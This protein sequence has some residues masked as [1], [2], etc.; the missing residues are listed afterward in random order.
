MKNFLLLGLALITG[1]GAQA[2]QNEKAAI[3]EAAYNFLMAYNI[4]DLP[5]A[6][7]YSDTESL[8]YMNMIQSF[9]DENPIPDSIM[10]IKLQI[11]IKIHPIETKITGDS[12]RV[13]YRL[14]M[15]EST[16]IPPS[17]EY[18]KMVKV[19]GRWLAHYTLMDALV[20]EEYAEPSDLEYLK[21]PNKRA[22]STPE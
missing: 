12:T 8:E 15:A 3:E 16:E 21:S 5:K 22:G 20:V 2:Q 9:L 10:K 6:I 4:S 19:G 11:E 17:E 18:I 7:K 14:V 1:L 13:Y